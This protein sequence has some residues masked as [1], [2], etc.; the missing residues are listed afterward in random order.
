MVGTQDVGDLPDRV[1]RVDLA[2]RRADDLL[3]VGDGEDALLDGGVGRDDQVVLIHAHAVV[4]LAFEHPDDAERNGP[5]ANDLPDGILSVGEELI[6][7]RPADEAHLGGSLD[8][9]L[10]EHVAVGHLVATDVE[11]I[12]VHAV[13]RRRGVVRP[14][15]RLPGAVDR[16]RDVG[17]IARV[18]PYVF[19]ILDLQRLHV[20]GAQLHASAPVAARVDHDHIRPHLADLGLNAALRPLA[21]GQHRD[22]RRHADDDAE[23][24]EESAQLVVTQCLDGYSEQIGEIHRLLLLFGQLRQG[25]GCA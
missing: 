4:A 5:E 15:N 24:R 6:D 20:V 14:V 23:H 1:V 2:Q 11:V 22:D 25:V 8:V 10:G 21:D 17:H 7:D 3:Q 13:D 19:E 9:V 16:R 18:G 12:E